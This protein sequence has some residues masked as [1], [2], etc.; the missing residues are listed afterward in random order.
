M[1]VLPSP[2]L[3]PEK[4]TTPSKTATKGT[5][6]FPPTNGEIFTPYIVKE[7]KDIG[8]S[9]ADSI[10]DDIINEATDLVGETDAYIDYED[11]KDNQRTFDYVLCAI[12]EEIRKAVIK[13]LK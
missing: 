3:Y 2:L 13:K 4:V 8:K 1:I 7:I 10:D 9:L 6:A 5:P 11:R 12:D